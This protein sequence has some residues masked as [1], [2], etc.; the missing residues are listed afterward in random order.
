[1]HAYLNYERFFKG[2]KSALEKIVIEYS[3]RLF[4][5]IKSY[6][7]DEYVAT[8]LV[9]D[10]FLALIVKK[11]KLKNEN[12]FKS[13]VYSIAKNKS[14]SYIKKHKQRTVPLESLSEISV[15]SFVDELEKK[16][17]KSVINSAIERLND[18]YKAVI[19]LQYY[20]DM[21]QK[22]I[23][24]V[25]GKSVKQIENLSFRA[26]QKLRTILKELG[27]EKIDLWYI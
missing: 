18:D 9:E 20:E 15:T 1:M 12:A 25:L 5:F 6:V 23:A 2:D 17:L 8:D 4:L 10:V 3:E 27:Y 24:K 22:E 7:R 26:K 14:L 13:Y 16:E 11:R 19:Y 21:S